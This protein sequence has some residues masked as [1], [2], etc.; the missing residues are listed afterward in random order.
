[1]V[2]LEKTWLNCRLLFLSLYVSLDDVSVNI[3]M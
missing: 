3:V 2:I 1:M